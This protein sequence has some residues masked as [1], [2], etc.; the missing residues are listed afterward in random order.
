MAKEKYVSA[1]SIIRKLTEQVKNN[2]GLTKYSDAFYFIALK[3]YLGLEENV[4]DNSI[5]D[6]SYGMSS[7][8]NGELRDNG[9]DAIYID[10]NSNIVYIFNFKFLEKPKFK[11][12]PSDECDKI[13]SYLDILFAYDETQNYYF[14]DK[15]KEKTKD[16]LSFMDDKTVEIKI[17]FASNYFDGLEK[18]KKEL[19]ERALSE[20][21]SNIT[22]EEIHLNDLI[23][24]YL[25]RNH[26]E[27]KGVCEVD[28]DFM[29]PKK[30]NGELELFIAK[31]KANNLLKLFIS[32]KSKRESNK[33]LTAT[34]IMSCKVDDQLFDDNV[35]IFLTKNNKTNKKIIETARHQ[36]DNFFFYNNGITIICDKCKVT[37]GAPS[38]LILSNYQVVNGGQTIHSIYEAAKSDYNC[39]TEVEVLCRIFAGTDESKKRQIARY[40]NT[41][42]KVS[43]RDLS[44]L[45]YIQMLLNEEFSLFNLKYERKKNQYKGIAQRKL[46]YDSHKTGQLLMAF[47]LGKPHIA[48]SN[49]KEVFSDNYVNQI[50]DQNLTAETII[51]LYRL[52]AWLQNADS[53]YKSYCRHAWLYVLY[54][55]RLVFE[56][57]RNETASGNNLEILEI[58]FNNID[59]FSQR[60]YNATFKVVVYIIERKK[61]STQYYDDSN[62]FKSEAPIKDFKDVLDT[63]GETLNDLEAANLTVVVQESSN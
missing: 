4:I 61:A 13:L 3:Y 50:F 14:N 22:F 26:I 27:Y 8:P 37:G 21:G 32:D 30:T 43:D 49:K 29:F 2:R 19:F 18:T 16:I 31:I 42:T 47:K 33:S 54:F 56:K 35:R 57:Y 52:N 53:K 1:Y 7:A 60:C 40:T 41:Q 62:Y 11:N 44:S 23:H 20:K 38:K 9:V 39:L 5:T 51:Q 55:Y 63:Y 6:L 59:D 34:E 48:R 58:E 36:P 15:L 17:V 12:Y 10:S 25:N 28:K 24:K 45:D 46:R